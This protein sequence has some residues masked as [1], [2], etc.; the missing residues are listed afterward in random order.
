MTLLNFEQS[1][2]IVERRNAGYG[3]YLADQYQHSR[4]FFQTV[5]ARDVVKYLEKKDRAVLFINLRLSVC[6]LISRGSGFV[7]ETE[8]KKE[9]INIPEHY[10]TDPRQRPKD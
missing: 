10:L 9:E 7:I 4:D 2:V 8:Y 1:I 3:V 5:L 6:K